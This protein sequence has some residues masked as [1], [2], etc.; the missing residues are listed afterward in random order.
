MNNYNNINTKTIKNDNIKINDNH[1]KAW[2]LIEIEQQ[3]IYNIE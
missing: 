3:R 2:L 1:I